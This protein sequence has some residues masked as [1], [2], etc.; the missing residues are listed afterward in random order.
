MSNRYGVVALVSGQTLSIDVGGSGLSGLVI[1]N[2]S[3]LT[4]VATMVGT[5]VQKTIYAGTVDSLTVPKGL[6]WSGNLLLTA[7]ADL[8]NA[9]SWPSSFANV[10]CYGFNEGISGT[11]PLVLNRATN[12]GNSVTTTGGGST[13]L[14]YDNGPANTV[15]IE[16][17]VVGSPSS[18]VS[19]DNSGSGWLGRWVTPTFT[20][21]F[22]WF[23]AGATALK[24][25]ATGLLTEVLGAL[26]IDQ[27]LTVIGSSN[28][29]NGALTSD[30]AG[31]LSAN[32]LATNTINNATSNTT[33]V[34]ASAVNTASEH[35]T[36]SMLYDNNVVFGWKDFGGTPQNGVTV[37]A[38]NVLTV[39]GIPGTEII[40][41]LKSDGSLMQTFNTSTGDITL[42]VGKL[43]LVLGSIKRIQKF[44]GTS[45]AGGKK[46]VN[47][48]MGETPD[49]VFVV[50]N[51]TSAPSAATIAIDYSTLS[52]TNIDVWSSLAAP[53]VGVAIKF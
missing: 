47:P 15:F 40:R 1:G 29:D 30:G 26:K 38:A 36:T 18:N 13:G 41:F 11:Y 7:T 5:G 31:N 22:Q 10:D 19:V 6:N 2:E 53:F 28:L 24:L 3:G 14:Q 42:S 49:L 44:T 27:T 46:S 20:K 33:T 52:A 23:G 39:W 50:Y 8:N 12:V 51:V 9:G 34:N 21:V 17:T 37:T 32:S 43:A 4:L 45:V 48:N 25:G 16:S 35:V